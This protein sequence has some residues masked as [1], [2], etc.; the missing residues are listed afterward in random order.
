MNRIL[1]LLLAVLSM[2]PIAEAQSYRVF[3]TDKGS[4]EH[5]LEQPEKFL[6]EAALLRRSMQG[7]EIDRSDLPVA[8][9]Y[10]KQ[11]QRMGGAVKAHSRW[12]NYAFVEGLSAEELEALTFVKRLEY[13]KKHRSQLAGTQAQFDYGLGTTQVELLNG[14]ALHQAGYTGKG[15]TIA[16]ID[17]GFTGALQAAVLDS[18]RQS[19][20]LMGSWSFINGDTNVYTGQGGHGASVLSVM[21][22]L[23]TGVFVGTA[24][25]ANYWLLTSENVSSETPV[26]MDHWLMAA[27]FAD[28]VGAHVINTSLGYTTFDDSTD[29]FDYSDM[30]G[31]TTVVTR[32]A[33]WAASK[34]IVVVA[35]AGNEGAGSWQRIGAPADGDSVLAVGATD[36]M[37]NYVNF[38]SRGPSYDW[39]VKPDV[40]AMGAGTT[41]INIVGQVSSGFGT[42]FSSPCIAGMAACLVQAKPNVHGEEIA[43]K[44]RRSAHLFSSPNNTLGYGIPDFEY[45]LNIGLEEVSPSFEAQVYPNPASN[46]VYLQGDF[47]RGQKL[48]LSVHNQAG[49]QLLAVERIWENQMEILDLSHLSPGVYFLSIHTDSMSH[50]LKLVKK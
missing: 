13:P 24:P 30:D 17:A 49:Q 3:F 34:G 14:D 15:V 50:Q 10:I 23:D 12:L 42:S 6:S 11:I 18:L 44:I 35:S 32:A 41:L 46:K 48:K 37:G 26:E 28:S 1:F 22:A 38:S 36:G 45:A 31:N 29:S 27:E 25:H 16:V 33:D 39:R 7:I 40:S 43:W 47:G 20:R 4:S 8:P 5:L 19:G 9:E 2:S 21:A